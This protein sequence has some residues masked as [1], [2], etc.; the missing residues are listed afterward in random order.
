MSGSLDACYSRR[1]LE[2]LAERDGTLSGELKLGKLTRLVGMLNS[3]AGS[4]RASLRFSQRRDGWLGA[5][6]DYQA[7]VE[8]VCQRCLV[9]FRYDFAG[10]VSLVL[11]DAESLPATVPEGHEPVEI[12]EG[13]VLPAQLIEDELIV[14]IPFAPKHARLADCGSLARD[15]I[16][17][18]DGSAAPEAADR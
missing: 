8:L 14:S 17:S 12:E 13:R 18:T 15:L 10:R 5:D 1:E 9:P 7:S 16:G 11:A 6:L 4:V 2:S 3:D